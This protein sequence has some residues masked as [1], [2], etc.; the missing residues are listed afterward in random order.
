LESV[1][2]NKYACQSQGIS[3]FNNYHYTVY[4]PTNESIDQLIAEGKLPTWEDVAALDQEDA[5]QKALAEKYTK[6]INEF[7]RY[8][9]QDNALFIHANNITATDDQQ[10]TGDV[11]TE[12]ETAFIDTQSQTFNKLSVTTDKS[13]ESITIK[14]KAGNVRR[15][16]TETGLFNLMAREY[17]YDNRDKSAARIIHNSS[18]AVVHLIDGPLL[19]ST[20]QNDQ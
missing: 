8:H 10:A 2:D 9:I 20:S 15:V 6:Q 7:L 13:G 11:T 5:A 14:D 18:S 19:V 4:V 16:M 3:A 17:Q 1:R 12:Y